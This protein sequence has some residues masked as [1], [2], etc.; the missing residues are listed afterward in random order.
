MNLFRTPA[1]FTQLLVS[2]KRDKD[3]NRLG[4]GIQVI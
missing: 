2:A 3:G 1:P 4:K